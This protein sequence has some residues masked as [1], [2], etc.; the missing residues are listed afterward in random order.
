MRAIRLTQNQTNVA[1]ARDVN[2]LASSFMGR[3]GS[4]RHNLVKRGRTD[5]ARTAKDR[6][7]PVHTFFLALFTSAQVAEYG[8]PINRPCNT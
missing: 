8:N 1:A 2:G 7:D 4:S 6:Q 3:T 5:G